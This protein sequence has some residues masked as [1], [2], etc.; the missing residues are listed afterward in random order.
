M[1]CQNLNHFRK[2]QGE[3][4]RWGERERDGKKEREREEEKR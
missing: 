1:L 2:F 3:E 4:G